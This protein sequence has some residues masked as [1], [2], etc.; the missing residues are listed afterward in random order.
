MPKRAGMFDEETKLFLQ[1][2]KKDPTF[3]ED[4]RKWREDWRARGPVEFA[5][6]ILKFDPNTAKPLN[7][8][9]GQ[10]SFL[11]DIGM[12]G[13]RLAIIAAGRG[14]GKTF[15]LAIYIMW[16]IFTHENYSI[17][18]MGGSQ[19]QSDIIASYISGWIRGNK[20]LENYCL[21]DI[22]KEIK[23]YS[24]SSASFHACSTT[25]ARGAHVNDVIIDEQAS[26]EEK[27]GERFIRAA[28]WQVS[29][30]PDI[31]IIQSSTAQYIYGDFLKT[32]NDAEKLGYKRYTWAIAKHI[33]G[34][35]DPYKIYQDVNPKNWKSNLPW[36]NDLNT[37]I[38]RTKKSNDEWLVEAL[39]GISISSGLVFNPLDLNACIC[40]RGECDVCK[41]Y[42]DGHCLY[43]IQRVLWQE[44]ITL[45]DL[46]K[47]TTDAIKQYVHER[48]L[49]IDWGRGSPTSFVVLGKFHD[50]VF[51]LEAHETNGLTDQEKVELAIELINKWE[52]DVVRPDPREWTLNGLVGEKTSAAIH[53]L[54]SG[55]EGGNEKYQY[56]AV[57][58]KFVERHR[59]IIPREE[60][61]SDLI[62]SLRNLTYDSTGKIR[63]Q[64]DHSADAMMYAI[65]YYD[66]TLKDASVWELPKNEQGTNLW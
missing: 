2:Q 26:G 55:P 52:V 51:V 58:K 66:E 31:H 21:K 56:V 53:E 63:K 6:K 48:V 40:D 62:R 23:T 46:P 60:I 34:E 37:E 35:K 54:F 57:L 45:T 17:S 5:Y 50:W 36:Q 33:S 29:T 9:E 61:F 13:V 59:L 1:H 4:Y 19:E 24:N 27:G 43:N 16:R 41:A 18:C 39:G 11:M 25:S 10:E 42:E 7:L 22:Q 12:N 30:S 14:S 64:D 65:S 15:V 28:I 44:G 49:G 8:S 47:L 38:L 20:I 32:W 3:H